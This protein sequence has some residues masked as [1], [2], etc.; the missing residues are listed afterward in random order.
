MDEASVEISLQTTTNNMLKINESTYSESS[1]SESELIPAAFRSQSTSLSRSLILPVIRDKLLMNMHNVNKISEI[2]AA[3]YNKIQ[4]RL[5]KQTA[6]LKLI[7][8]E[9]G[10]HFLSKKFVLVLLSFALVLIDVIFRGG[11]EKS[12]IGVDQWDFIDWL[13][14]LI[15]GT[16]AFGIAI[17]TIHHLKFGYIRKRKAAY[18]FHLSDMHWNY[19]SGIRISIFALLCGLTWGALEISEGW[20]YIP[21][22]I[23]LGKHPLVASATGMY[24]SIILSSILALTYIFEGYFDDLYPLVIGIVSLIAAYIGMLITDLIVFKLK[25]SAVLICMISLL[26]F[27]AAGVIPTSMLHR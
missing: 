2:R 7:H 23:S 20:I 17:Y 9:E 15:L 22:L 26:G 12:L 3:V 11:A 8:I 18:F 10:S 1:R 16:I 25:R 27:L 21:L 6:L 4:G 14:F 24:I 5:E 19:S 13:L